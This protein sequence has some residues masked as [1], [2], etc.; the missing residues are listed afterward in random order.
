[1]VCRWKRIKPGP[2][3]TLISRV[4]HFKQESL[5][6]HLAR[7]T[8]QILENHRRAQVFTA[9]AKPKNLPSGLKMAF[10]GALFRSFRLTVPYA[11]QRHT[12]AG[13]RQEHHHLDSHYGCR[14]LPSQAAML[15]GG[16]LARPEVQADEFGGR[17]RKEP[18]TDRPRSARLPTGGEGR[19][20]RQPTT[21]GRVSRPRGRRLLGRPTWQRQSGRVRSS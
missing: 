16:C 1:M 17:Q 15:L 21:K 11:H 4:E 3:F 10:F 8:Q 7:P 20:G 6:P 13:N 5:S 2:P 19:P 12:D 18:P 9:T 14:R